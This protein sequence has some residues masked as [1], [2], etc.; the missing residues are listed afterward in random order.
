MAIGVS[1]GV[2][3]GDAHSVDVCVCGEAFSRYRRARALLIVYVPSRAS[4]QTRVLITLPY[5]CRMLNM[6]DSCQ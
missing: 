6:L 5:V 2:G 4:H 1:V 3:N